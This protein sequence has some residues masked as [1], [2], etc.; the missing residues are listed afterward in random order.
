[1]FISHVIYK[2]A[3]YIDLKR[4]KPG[5]PYKEIMED[6]ENNKM[7]DIYRSM[8]PPKSIMVK[9][10]IKDWLSLGILVDD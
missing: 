8:Y 5:T 1:M 7:F 10:V 6:W 2:E 9:K 3:L 4:Y